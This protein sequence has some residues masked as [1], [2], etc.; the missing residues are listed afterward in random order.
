MLL[1]S[2]LPV[3]YCS[4]PL[5]QEFIEDEMALITPY[6]VPEFTKSAAEVFEAAREKFGDWRCYDARI[7]I[8]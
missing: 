3:R 1:R 2:Y 8:H 5:V 6:S 7:W 4:D